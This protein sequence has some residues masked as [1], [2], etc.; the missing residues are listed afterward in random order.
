MRRLKESSE[1]VLTSA[2]DR[3]IVGIERTFR[4][5]NMLGSEIIL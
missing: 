2:R 3:F 1:K 4:T 5:W